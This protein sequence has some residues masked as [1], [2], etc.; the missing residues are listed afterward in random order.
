MQDKPAH[1]RPN[2]QEPNPADFAGFIRLENLTKGYLEAGRERLVLHDA[3]LS[4]AQGEL[5]AILGKS[6]SGKTTL[7][8]L[9]SGIDQAEKGEVYVDGLRLTGMSDRERTMFRREKIG[10][11]FQFFNLIP[12]LTVWENLTLPLELNGMMD[13]AGAAAGGEP[14]GGSGLGRADE[15]T[16]P[17][18][19]FGRR[20]A[21]RG[22]R[23][24]AGARSAAGAGR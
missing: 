20:A 24:G 16:Y 14:A 7:L 6:G 8:N 12:T 21:A 18:P 19:A 11:I 23:P 3:N 9:I 2:G 15:K 1:I 5:I 22:D 10:F 4:M 17:G 13:A